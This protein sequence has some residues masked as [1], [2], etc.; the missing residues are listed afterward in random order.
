VSLSS[1][2]T[3]LEGRGLIRSVGRPEESEF[4]FRHTLFQEAAYQ[5]LLRGERTDLH[6]S[7]AVALERAYA[8]DEEA[9]APVLAYQFQQAGDDAKALRYFTLAA[10]A[11]AKVYA[12][13]EAI[14]HYQQA[15]ELALKVDPD[16][17]RLIELYTGC[18]RLH[19]LMGDFE[20]A[21]KVYDI[22]Q[23]RSREL[24]LPSLDIK[25]RVARDTLH[26]SPSAVSNHAGAKV[27]ARETLALA[28]KVGDREAEARSLWNLMLSGFFVGEE[29]VSRNDGEQA[30][31]IAR[32]IGDRTLQA[33]IMNDLA[34]GY[35]FFEGHQDR[36]MELLD[37]AMQLWTELDNLP[38]LTDSLGS[39]AM[40]AGYSGQYQSCLEHAERALEISTQIDNPWGKSY[41]QYIMNSAYMDLGDFPRALR[42]G[43]ESLEWAEVAGFVV[44]QA[45][46][47]ANQAWI[48]GSLG[49]YDRAMEIADKG[50]ASARSSLSA[51]LP[52]PL[53][54]KL[55]VNVWKRDKS[56]AAAQANELAALLS[57]P[58]AELFPFARVHAKI[59]LAEF[60]LAMGQHQQAFDLSDDLLRMQ[61][62]MNFQNLKIDALIQ[63]SRAA[64]ELDDEQTAWEALE[65]AQAHAQETQAKRCLWV[66]LHL[67]AQLSE[68]RGDA[69]K[70]AEYDSQARDALEVIA[71]Q[72]DNSLRESFLATPEAA[73]VWSA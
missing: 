12:N 6:R 28:R 65:L 7:V 69:D 68:R 26:S 73:Q 44:P 30:L 22:M 39:A 62:K 52:I 32:Q 55:L 57:N 11:A 40:V 35:F 9:V 37:E 49:Q 50:V 53:A 4:L 54:S 59:G 72:L 71:N 46:V 60:H 8:D 51:W 36:G 31:E 43:D 15:I 20:G 21:I 45:A 63:R 48:Y 38:M 27:G 42:V 67:M 14:E 19:E 24:D 47:R 33:F 23:A 3:A 25:A 2:L 41:A 1:Q 10:Q 56:S 70:A 66:V 64:V 18:G 34:R 13:Q 5:S 16:P 61:A 58:E 29:K 17:K